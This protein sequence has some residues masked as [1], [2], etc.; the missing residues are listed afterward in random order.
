MNGFFTQMR[1]FLGIF[2]LA[3]ALYPSVAAGASAPINV[4]F[5]SQAPRGS[6]VSP[7]KDY[8]EEGSVVMAAHFIW[9]APLT[10]EIAELEMGIIRQFEIAAFGRWRDTGIEQTA[11]IL[12]RLYGFSGISTAVISS[13]EEIKAALAAGNVVIAPTAGRLLKNPFFTPPGPV[14][15][16]IVIRGFDRAKK[17]F[18]VNDPGTRRGD[19]LRYAEEILFNAI[20]DL[21][22]GD[23]LHGAKRVMVVGRN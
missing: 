2:A 23:T 12:R 21:N 15:H 14:Y 20:H 5:T 17:E 10:P 19:G 3:A 11:D 16:M 9:G 22:S 7:W 13:P 4:P 6:W 8:C 1:G 18:I